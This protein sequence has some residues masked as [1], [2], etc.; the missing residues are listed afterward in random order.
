MR[1]ISFWFRYSIVEKAEIIAFFFEN[2]ECANRTT[3]LFNQGY[4]NKHVNRKYV[5]HVVAKFKETRCMI[6]K[7]RNAERSVRNQV[8][9]AALICCGSYAANEYGEYGAIGCR[10]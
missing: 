9:V 10:I 7:K 2:S 1:R 5:L 8:E 4:V 3:E 6:N